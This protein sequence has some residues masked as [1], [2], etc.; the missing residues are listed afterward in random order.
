MNLNAVRSMRYRERTDGRK[1]VEDRG[2]KSLPLAFRNEDPSAAESRANRIAISWLEALHLYVTV[3]LSLA[4]RNL[5]RDA[6]AVVVQGLLMDKEYMNTETSLSINK[7]FV[8][9]IIAMI[10]H[11]ITVLLCTIWRKVF[12]ITSHT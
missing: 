7:S 10:L 11:L 9:T 6:A 8:R 1:M 3:C 4:S 2:T 12:A 5:C